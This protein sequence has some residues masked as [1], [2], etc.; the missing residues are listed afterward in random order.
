MKIN[1]S[2]NKAETHIYRERAVKLYVEEYL[3]SSLMDRLLSYPKL[4]SLVNFVQDVSEGNL[5]RS[6][7]SSL[8]S[9]VSQYIYRR[10]P[11]NV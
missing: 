3:T 6:D 10:G 4:Q 8:Q 5:I 7:T 1:G 9:I 11:F 2:Y